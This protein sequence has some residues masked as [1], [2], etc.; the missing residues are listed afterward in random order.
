MYLIP[1]LRQLQAQVAHA[2]LG[3]CD[4]VGTPGE[5]LS[6]LQDKQADPQEVLSTGL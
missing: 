2:H 6:Q 3:L 1:V 4:V 5:D